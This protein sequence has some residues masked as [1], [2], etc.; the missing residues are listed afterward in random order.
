MG[1]LGIRNHRQQQQD[2][3]SMDKSHSFLHSLIKHFKFGSTTER[4]NEVD[5]QRMASQEQK[6]FSYETLVSATKN[7]NAVHKLGE[8][9]F[10]P[11][12]KVNQFYCLQ[13]N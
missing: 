10:G 1:C 13:I 11:V 9:G 6:I 8:G 3:I 4:N 5:L 12:F 2:T 7:F